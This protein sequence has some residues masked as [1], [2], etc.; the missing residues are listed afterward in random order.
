MQIHAL[1]I[2]FK[3]LAIDVKR[4]H[5]IAILGK[6]VGAIA[7]RVAAQIR[8]VKLRIVVQDPLQFAAS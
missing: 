4:I 1:Q 3:R 5:S 8:N 6:T 7:C 2:Q